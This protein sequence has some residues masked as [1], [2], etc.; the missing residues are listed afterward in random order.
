VRDL[1]MARVVRY[2]QA[3]DPDLP[4]ASGYYDPVTTRF[5]KATRLAR[6]KR[7]LPDECFERRSCAAEKELAA[8]KG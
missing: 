3:V 5:I 7:A 1:L 6:K 4:E 8:Q 2:H